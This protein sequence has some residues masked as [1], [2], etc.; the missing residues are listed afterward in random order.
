MEPRKASVVAHVTY[1]VGLQ[2]CPRKSRISEVHHTIFGHPRNEPPRLM[3][4]ATTYRNEPPRSNILWATM[5]DFGHPHSHIMHAQSYC[6]G[7]PRLGALSVH[8]ECYG[9]PCTY[10]VSVHLR[11]MQQLLGDHVAWLH[12]HV[13]VLWVS[14]T[15]IWATITHTSWACKSGLWT[16]T[17]NVVSDHIRNV[18]HPGI[19]FGR[20]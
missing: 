2:I 4:W 6:V 19:L 5:R 7:L 9:Q 14:V 3:L 20:P 10:I 16:S 13:C 1:I 8:V 11:P 17:S 15:D 12:A 18:W